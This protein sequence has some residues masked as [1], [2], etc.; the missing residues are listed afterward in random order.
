MTL[1]GA[2]EL[3]TKAQGGAHADIASY[4]NLALIGASRFACSTGVSI[5]DIS[6]PAKPQLLA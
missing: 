4:E 2:L 1:V 3:E 5:V 6:N